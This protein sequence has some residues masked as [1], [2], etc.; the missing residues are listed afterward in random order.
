LTRLLVTIASGH[1]M[2]DDGFSKLGVDGR[3]M[4]FGSRRSA[5]DP[6]RAEA[7]NDAGKVTSIDVGLD[8]SGR[9]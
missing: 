7:I 8:L 2:L 3:N 6:E 5:L 9:I 1:S 4:P